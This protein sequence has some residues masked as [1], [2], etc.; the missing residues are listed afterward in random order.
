V[1]RSKLGQQGNSAIPGFTWQPPVLDTASSDRPVAPGMS[2]EFPVVQKYPIIKPEQ[3]ARVHGLPVSVAK[4]IHAT[5]IHPDK[6]DMK[7]MYPAANRGSRAQAPSTDGVLVPVYDPN[8]GL[9]KV[10][11]YGDPVMRNI[12]YLGGDRLTGPFASEFADK[13]PAPWAA[14]LALQE[15]TITPP[16]WK[17]AVQS[18][19]TWQGPQTDVPAGFTPPPNPRFPRKRIRGNRGLGPVRG[20]VKGKTNLG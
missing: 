13:G 8:T 2:P 16:A 17:A 20:G 7:D 6:V 14:R 11:R 10:D 4:R 9:P 3:P 18:G 15:Q 12:P 5:L 1:A 19:Q